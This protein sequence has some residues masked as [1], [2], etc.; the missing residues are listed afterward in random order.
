VNED[1]SDISGSVQSELRA[2]EAK[3]A[4]Q[5]SVDPE[6]LR[7]ELS[8]IQL[9]P[10][11]KTEFGTEGAIIDGHEVQIHVVRNFPIIFGAYERTRRG[12]REKDSIES[13]I[14]TASP[15]LRYGEIF[16]RFEAEYPALY[17][18]MNE[19]AVNTMA[20]HPSRSKIVSDEERQANKASEEELDEWNY[21]ASCAYNEMAIIAKIIDSEYNL[22]NL[23]LRPQA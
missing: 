18:R 5:S 17:A 13:L 16:A 2:L 23:Y 14:T 19:V 21:I 3:Q 10:E 4:R 6:Q 8:R 12:E 7:L 11:V 22:K 1:I 20:Q 9:N 15:R